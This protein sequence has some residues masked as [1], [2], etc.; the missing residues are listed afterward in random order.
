MQCKRQ[1]PYLVSKPTP[2]ADVWEIRLSDSYWRGLVNAARQRKCSFSNI[3]RYCIFRLAERQ[4]LTWRKSLLK[5]AS[6]AKIGRPSS[7]QGHR[8]LVCFYGE[9]IKLVR[10]A[11]LNLGI[12]VSAFVRLA[13]YLFLPRLALDNHSRRSVSARELLYLGI[14]RWQHVHHAALNNYNIP[15]YRR[16]TFSNFFPW[17]WWPPAF[18]IA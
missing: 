5:A 18:Q 3:T 11:A 10:I 9:D 6:Q 15:L 8:H 4:N 2:I 13:L 16:F 12:N 14:K 7:R 1:P 17:Q